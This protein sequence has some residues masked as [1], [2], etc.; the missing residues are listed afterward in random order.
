MSDSRRSRD[1]AG[2][3]RS[4]ALNTSDPA[5]ADHARML[6]AIW[7]EIAD[8]TPRAHADSGARAR[9]FALVD[10]AAGLGAGT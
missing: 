9:I 8:L 1:R 7:T 5:T 3:Y 4:L 2:A 6:E 10:R